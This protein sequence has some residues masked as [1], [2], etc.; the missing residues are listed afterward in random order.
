MV[1]HIESAAHAGLFEELKQ[2]RAAAI[3]HYLAAQR[4]LRRRPAAY[5]DMTWEPKQS[6]TTVADYYATH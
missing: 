3:E 1:K 4:A 2:V 6:F 5:P